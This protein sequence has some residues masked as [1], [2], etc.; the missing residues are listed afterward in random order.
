MT[1]P[2]RPETDLVASYLRLYRPA[3]SARDIRVSIPTQT[4]P[5]GMPQ[6]AQRNN[7]PG[8]LRFAEQSGASQGEGGFARFDTPELGYQALIRQIQ[9]DQS[10]GLPFGAFIAKYAP[11][12]ENDTAGYVRQIASRLRINPGIPLSHLPVHELAKLIAQKESGAS[13]TDLLPIGIPAP[14]PQGTVTAGQPQPLRPGGG[15]QF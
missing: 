11:P 13:V 15:A 6:F 14:A 1:P 4:Q 5:T 10:R 3:P 7:N 9:L 8:N 2:V 12:S